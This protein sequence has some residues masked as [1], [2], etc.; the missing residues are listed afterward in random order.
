MDRA[1]DYMSFPNGICTLKDHVICQ[2]IGP[3]H[4]ECRNDKL[5]LIAACTDIYDPHPMQLEKYV[6]KASFLDALEMHTV[7]IDPRMECES[8]DQ[9]LACY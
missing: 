4:L 3:K 7:L 1:E 8:Y 5:E 9:A 6:Y 2:K